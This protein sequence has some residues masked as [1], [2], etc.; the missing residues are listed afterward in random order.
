MINIGDRVQLHGYEEIARVVTDFGTA[1][2]VTNN[3]SHYLVLT[4]Q[5][6]DEHGRLESSHCYSGRAVT[7]ALRAALTSMT[8]LAIEYSSSLEEDEE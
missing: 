8:E 7:A 4:V 6:E 5:P 3:S 1:R 2:V